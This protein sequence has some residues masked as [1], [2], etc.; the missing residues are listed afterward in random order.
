ML[1]TDGSIISVTDLEDFESGIRAVCSA[2]NVDIQS[3]LDLATRLVIA[4]IKSDL[5][6]P[7]NTYW[8]PQANAASLLSQDYNT[9]RVRPEWIVVT[10]ELNMWLTM[11][12]LE[13]IYSDCWNR[14]MNDKYEQKM[15]NYET[16]AKNEMARYFLIGVAMVYSPLPRP[17]APTVASASGGSLP[18]QNLTLQFTWV[19]NVGRESAPCLPVNSSVLANNLTVLSI[20]NYNV[21]I[22]AGQQSDDGQTPWTVGTAIS[23]NVYAG[24]ANNPPDVP[25]TLQATVPI[26]SLNW[27]EP[28]SG[29][30]TTGTPLRPAQRDATLGQLPD[31]YRTQ[32]STFSRT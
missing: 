11:K 25:L 28:V 18:A 10:S 13:V 26:S 30:T 16:Q 24:L 2:N 3:K 1:L 9:L 23:W 31:A 8:A 22:P 19:N 17:G 20:N 12:A 4:E 6:R 5:V 27:V 14:K 7:S 32:S 21:T 15:L 29:V